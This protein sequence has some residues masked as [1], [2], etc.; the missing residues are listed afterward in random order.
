[1]LRPST[2][3]LRITTTKSWIQMPIPGPTR[4]LRGGKW[5]VMTFGPFTQKGI[6]D[7]AAT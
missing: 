4:D 3:L 2:A 7:V 6:A 5:G 1:M